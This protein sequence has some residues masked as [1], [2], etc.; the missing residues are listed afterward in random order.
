MRDE[1]A[2]RIFAYHKEYGNI[3]PWYKSCAIEILSIT[4]PPVP[5]DVP[6]DKCGGEGSKSELCINTKLCV[7]CGN[8]DPS[9][10][11]CITGP[12]TC[13]NGNN[14]R[15]VE[16]QYLYQENDGCWSSEAKT[17]RLHDLLD[18]DVAWAY[19]NLVYVVNDGH[20][21]EACPIPNNKGTL[22]I[23]EG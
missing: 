4:N 11:P 1:I 22:K 17:L 12:C 20:I 2:E 6:C 23:K 5:V 16:Y 3:T 7:P 21:N 10:I 9:K 13:D 15:E 8:P 18:P 19:H 14:K